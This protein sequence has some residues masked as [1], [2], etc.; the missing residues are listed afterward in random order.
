[1]SG[2]ANPAIDQRWGAAALQAALQPALPGLQ[3]QVLPE[4]DSTNS[5]LMRRFKGRPG[6]PPQMV[7]DRMA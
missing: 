1:M 3:V 7:V 2:T 6:Q 4:I 5:E